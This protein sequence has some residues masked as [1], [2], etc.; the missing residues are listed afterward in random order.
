VFNISIK[1]SDSANVPAFKIN[2]SVAALSGGAAPA[3][4]SGTKDS[5]PLAKA[6]SYAFTWPNPSSNKWK[7][8]SYRLTVEADS[9][10]IINDSNRQNNVKTFDFTVA[11]KATGS[12]GTATSVAGC[13]EASSFSGGNVTADRT[14]TKD[15]V[16]VAETNIKTALVGLGCTI[17]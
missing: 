16:D 7:A 1:D 3:E 2:I 12:A 8:G 6:A 14:L 17:R 9:G 10:K 11:A 5:V 4:L 15:E 13:T